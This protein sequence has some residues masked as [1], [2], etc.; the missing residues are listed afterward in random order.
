MK[1]ETTEEGASYLRVSE[2]TIARTADYGAMDVLAD[3]TADG[4][5]IGLEFLGPEAHIMAAELGS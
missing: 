1:W 4:T 2:G 5:L 3:V